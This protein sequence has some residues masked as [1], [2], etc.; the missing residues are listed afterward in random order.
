VR[1]VV[2]GCGNV[3]RGDDAAGPAL[4]RR[5]WETG[6]PSEVRCIDGG[7]GGLDLVF[8]IRGAE[9]VIFVDACRWGGEPGAVYEVPGEQVENLP[10]LSGINLHG[11]RWDHAI[12]LGRRLLAEDYPRRVT[13][14]LIEG[15]QFEI[16]ASLSPEVDRAVSR[17]A[18][19]ICRAAW[20]RRGRSRRR[21]DPTCP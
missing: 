10:P 6:L 7:T 1:T 14:Y 13:A 18:A 8:Q 16:G 4:V 11:I 21:G 12:A 20:M 15:R 9:K 3:L 5:L 17:L 2:I 19:R